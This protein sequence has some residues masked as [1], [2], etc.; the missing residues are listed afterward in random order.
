M[1]INKTYDIKINLLVYLYEPCSKENS[2]AR[3][4]NLWQELQDEANRHKQKLA[5]PVNEIMS[6]WTTQ[7]GFPV[8][9]VSIE[10][11]VATMTQKRFLLRNLK[12]TPTNAKWWIPITW[13][14]KDD[15]NFDVVKVSHWMSKEQDSINLGTSPGWVVLNVQSAGE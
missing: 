12:A 8:V 7:A 2:V 5:A 9:T 4:E 6:T 1:I 15:S 11:G 10:N 3:P 13:A 14:S